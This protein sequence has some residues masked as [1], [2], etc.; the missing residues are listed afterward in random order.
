MEKRARKSLCVVLIGFLAFFIVYLLFLPDFEPR[1]DQAPAL[2]FTAI[3]YALLSTLAATAIDRKRLHRQHWLI[4]G[5]LLLL[6]AAVFLPRDGDTLNFYMLSLTPFIV[7]SINL[8]IGVTVALGFLL[9]IS[10]ASDSDIQTKLIRPFTAKNILIYFGI[11]CTF[12]FVFWALTKFRAPNAIALWE[13]PGCIGAGISEEVLFRLLPYAFA[14]SLGH[15]KINAKLLTFLLM[16]V[17]FTLMHFVGAFLTDGF[18]TILPAMLQF[19]VIAA[20]PLTLLF[21][22]RDL[23]TAISV[24]ILWEVLAVTFG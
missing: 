24:H 15:G 3:L 11:L 23:F 4:A 21:L 9:V 17:P 14:L 7:L 8:L 10:L 18:L 13:I 6:S 16:S 1:F 2:H 12:V 5:A 20:V 19:W 22:K